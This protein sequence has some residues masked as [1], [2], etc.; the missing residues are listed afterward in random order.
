[1]V[2]RLG[3]WLKRPRVPLCFFFSSRRRHTRYWRD[4]SS[5]VCSSDL[6]V[7]HRVELLVRRVPRLEQ[8][9]VDIDD[10]DRLDGGVGVRVRGQQRA[11]GPREQVHRLLEIGRASGRGR[12]QISWVAGSLKKKKAAVYG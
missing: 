2:A 3:P 1:M 11:A 5:N 9:G 10:V 8:V 7:D 6:L 4:W 12:V